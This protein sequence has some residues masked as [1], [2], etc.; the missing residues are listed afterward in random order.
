MFKVIN[1]GLMAAYNVYTYTLCT[2][3][4][5]ISGWHCILVYVCDVIERL[6]PKAC[7]LKVRCFSKSWK[8]PPTCR[9]QKLVKTAQH[10]TLLRSCRCVR[11]PHCVSYD[12]I[13]TGN[14][15][16]PTYNSKNAKRYYQKTT[17]YNSKNAKI[18]FVTKT[19]HPRVWF[20]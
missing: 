2:F 17:T 8:A 18:Y 6:N 9:V 14:R 16:T 4:Q 7:C 10:P 11:L 20:M 12:I 5:K 1:V 13:T 19:G 3:L 15:K